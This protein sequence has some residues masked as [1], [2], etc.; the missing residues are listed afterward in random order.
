[1][2]RGAES[3]LV[4]AFLGLRDL[5]LGYAAVARRSTDPREVRA[6]ARDLAV[7]L[8]RLPKAAAKLT[9][10]PGDYP[11]VAAALVARGTELV[12]RA[13]R[14]AQALEKEGDE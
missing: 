12:S 8:E 10:L 13:E 3:D 4:R 11:S 1:M 6:A 5:A 14:R 2:T 9:D 7:T